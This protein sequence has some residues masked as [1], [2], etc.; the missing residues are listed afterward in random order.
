MCMR[1]SLDFPPAAIPIVP[2]GPIVYGGTGMSGT[3]ETTKA[4][5][6]SLAGTG[7]D[8]VRHYL[9]HDGG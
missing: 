9:G 3:I 5:P 6:P 7:V 1:S 8:P 4:D 2:G